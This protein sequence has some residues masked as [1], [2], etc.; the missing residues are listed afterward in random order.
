MCYLFL[1]ISG[2]LTI[3]TTDFAALVPGSYFLQQLR[4][5]LLGQD[6]PYQEKRI[7]AK[8]NAIWAPMESS[9]CPCPFDNI[10]DS[11]DL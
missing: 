4:E 2:L 8:F 10:P 5:F 11:S 9:A 6:D 7:P 3:I 1:V